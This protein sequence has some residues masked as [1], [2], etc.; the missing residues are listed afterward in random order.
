MKNFTKISYLSIMLT[1]FAIA[2]KAP[3]SSPEEQQ[4]RVAEATQTPGISIHEMFKLRQMWEDLQS[5]LSKDFS[6]TIKP[7]EI[8]LKNNEKNEEVCI[9]KA[10]LIEMILEAY[11]SSQT[12]MLAHFQ[13]ILTQFKQSEFPKFNIDL[14]VNTPP[15]YPGEHF[16]QI[17]PNNKPS[18][19]IKATTPNESLKAEF[20]T[21]VISNRQVEISTT[22]HVDGKFDIQ[23][24]GTF[25]PRNNR[26]KTYKFYMNDLNPRN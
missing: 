24:E 14:K 17:D 3:Q 23:A 5:H 18:I 6:F 12:E 7:N 10:I 16:E 8:C 19:H 26:Y 22:A 11:K 9:H 1:T 20:N 4:N 21:E 2:E 15:V 25:N 13:K